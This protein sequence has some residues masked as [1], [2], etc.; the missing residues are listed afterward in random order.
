MPASPSQVVGWPAVWIPNLSI[1]LSAVGRIANTPIEPV[2]V[3]GSAI[4]SSDA[5]DTQ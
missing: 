3:F 4:T 5:I 1:T 2:M